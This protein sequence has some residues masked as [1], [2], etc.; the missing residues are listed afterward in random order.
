[1]Y[2]FSAYVVFFVE[3]FFV[4][5]YV[6]QNIIKLIEETSTKYFALDTE[7]LSMQGRDKQNKISE[8]KL[9]ISLLK[10]ILIKICG[11]NFRQKFEPM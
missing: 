4:K 3:T 11:S 1:M 7:P 6:I 8:A 2:N 10:A 5:I 9:D